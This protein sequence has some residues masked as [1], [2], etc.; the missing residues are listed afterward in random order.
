V[1]FIRVSQDG[2]DQVEVDPAHRHTIKKSLEGWVDFD[3]CFR[4]GVIEGEICP[5][6]VGVGVPP[7]ITGNFAQEKEYVREVRSFRELQGECAPQKQSCNR[8]P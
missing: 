8:L 3:S 1:S 5:Y 7:A 6:E 4:S 2:Y